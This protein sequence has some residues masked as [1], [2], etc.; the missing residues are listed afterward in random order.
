MTNRV[1]T[2]NI[3]VK[4]PSTQEAAQLNNINFIDEFSS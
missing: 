4:L 1:L 3:L 2:L